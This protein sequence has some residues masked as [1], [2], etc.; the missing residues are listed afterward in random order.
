MP[1]Y[2][3]VR[4]AVLSLVAAAFTLTMLVVVRSQAQP[5]VVV[6][7]QPAA[8][9]SHLFVPPVVQF[10][11]CWGYNRWQRTPTDPRWWCGID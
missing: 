11:D 5:L 2:L 3:A 8:Y 4:A 7:Q 1:I 9:P 10:T 6:V